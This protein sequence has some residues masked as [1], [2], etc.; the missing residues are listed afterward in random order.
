MRTVPKVFIGG[1]DDWSANISV[2]YT[3]CNSV[4]GIPFLLWMSE[5]A[6]GERGMGVDWW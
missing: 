2:Y 1:C 3:M 5:N 4:D 6:G